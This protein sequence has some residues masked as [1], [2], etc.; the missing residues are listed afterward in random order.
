MPK[1]TAAKKTAIHNKISDE[2]KKCAKRLK[3]HCIFMVAVFPD[4][5]IVHV[6]TG[7]QTIEP[8]LMSLYRSLMIMEQKKLIEGGDDGLQED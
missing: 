4:Q 7:G 8:D 1:W 3:A 2:A 6:M 5:D